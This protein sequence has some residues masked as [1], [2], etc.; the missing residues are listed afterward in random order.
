MEDQDDGGVC[1]V[2]TLAWAEPRSHA[3]SIAVLERDIGLW[4]MAGARVP[5]VGAIK[6]QSGGP[7]PSPPVPTCRVAFV[8][9]SG[10]SVPFVKPV[11]DALRGRGCD[12]RLF[13]GAEHLG[14]SGLEPNR[15]YILVEAL[16]RRTS[17]P[18]VAQMQ[19]LAALL[20]RGRFDLIVAATP[21]AML[22]SSLASIRF[23]SRLLLWFWGLPAESATGV[24]GVL[25]RVADQLSLRACDAAWFNSQ[26]LLDTATAVY[27]SM[28]SKMVFS[29]PGTTHGI[30]DR[31]LDADP[32]VH[33]DGEALTVGYVG[34][35]AGDKG[36]DDL[37]RGFVERGFGARGLRLLLVGPL[38]DRDPILHETINT[39]VSHPQIHW[40]GAVTDPLPHY[41]E[42]GVLAFPSRREGFP[43]APLE[44]AALGVPTVGFDATGTRDAVV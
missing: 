5:V 28:R 11:A 32:V 9:S 20:H 16:D 19:R 31:F 24:S 7:P 43:N 1:A 18:R 13:A 39:I 44:A 35:L 4:C 14:I 41:R 40:V 21:K 42:M 8:V 34:R 6:M 2:G 25:L 12:V 37:V 29:A 26:S 30:A 33:R 36:V 17:L 23:S 3:E 38:D 15:D 10:A 27:P 22:L